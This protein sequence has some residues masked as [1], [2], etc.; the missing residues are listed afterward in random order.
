MSLEDKRVEIANALGAVPN[1]IGY[2]YRP[3]ILI[4]GAGWPIL[5]RPAARHMS[6]DA[7]LVT[8]LVRV[9]T[10]SDEVAATRWWDT[11]WP[12]VYEALRHVGFI[13]GFDPVLLDA[14]GSTVFAFEI[15]LRTEE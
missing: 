14:G 11:R 12:F 6:G 10:P 3:E 9:V 2:A 1:V 5:A 7:Y 8:W 15:V 4:E 13:E